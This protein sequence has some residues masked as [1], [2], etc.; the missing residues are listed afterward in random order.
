MYSNFHRVKTLDR[1]CPECGV[2]RLAIIEYVFKKDGV[3]FYEDYEECNE[4]DYSV[5]I[6]TK[7]KNKEDF[8]ESGW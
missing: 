7:N 4:C 8:S 3:E 1:R 6:K 5:R 2:G